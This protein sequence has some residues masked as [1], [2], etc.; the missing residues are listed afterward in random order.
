[1]FAIV[2]NNN[3]NNKHWNQWQRIAGVAG[4]GPQLSSWDEVGCA[5]T[6]YGQHQHNVSI[7]HMNT[8][9]IFLI[10]LFAMLLLRSQCNT[11][12]VIFTSYFISSF[13][14]VILLVF[15]TKRILSRHF[16]SFISQREINFIKNPTYERDKHN[17]KN[18]ESVGHF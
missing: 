13:S 3:F 9:P 15:S 10:L 12:N 16:I 2:I 6:S 5:H 4:G 18:T 1:M 7:R 14:L 17:L 8:H 11:N